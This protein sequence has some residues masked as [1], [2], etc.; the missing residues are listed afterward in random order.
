[1]A[2]IG[3]HTVGS[4]SPT[5]SS[6][7]PIT[8]SALAL[9]VSG[10]IPRSMAEFLLAGQSI[11]TKACCDLSIYFPQKEKAARMDSFRVHAYIPA[12][13]V[14]LSAELSTALPSLRLAS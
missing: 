4:F 12:P 1:M 14:S 5:H 7:R 13:W 2:G 11:L 10:G 3:P 9:T 6:I 8:I